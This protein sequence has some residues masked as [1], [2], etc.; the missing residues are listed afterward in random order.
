MSNTRLADDY[1]AIRTR[2]Q[3]I[4]IDERRA[5][6]DTVIEEIGRCISRSFELAVQT[7]IFAA[8]NVQV[9]VGD[10]ALAG[11]PAGELR[12]PLAEYKPGGI[13]TTQVTFWADNR[14]V[15]TLPPDGSAGHLR[16]WEAVYRLEP[17]VPCNAEIA[18]AR[19][20]PHF[21]RY[22]GEHLHYRL[23]PKGDAA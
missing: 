4:Q 17:F 13:Q 18:W 8:E 5:D 23:L 1:S 10:V 12:L 11:S 2:M 20:F 7:P 21:K 15:Y 6:A 14:M 9:T 22:P 16:D 3:Q 19:D